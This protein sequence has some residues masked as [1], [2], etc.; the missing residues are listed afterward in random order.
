MHCQHRRMNSALESRFIAGQVANLEH[1]CLLNGAVHF[2]RLMTRIGAEHNSL[3]ESFS[4]RLHYVLGAQT[5]ALE[6]D[7]YCWAISRRLLRL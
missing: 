1:D 5:R 3:V 7:K 6:S 2:L 4:V